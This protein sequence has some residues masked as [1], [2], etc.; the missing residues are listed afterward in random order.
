MVDN[1]PNRREI[2][3]LASGGLC[4]ASVDDI[5]RRAGLIAGIP[6]PANA[7]SAEMIELLNQA[8]NEVAAAAGYSIID[9]VVAATTANILLSG[10]QTIDDVAVVPT[11]RV[12]VKNQNSGSENGVYIAASGAWSRAADFNSSGAAVTGALVQVDGGDQAGAWALATKGMITVGTTEQTWQPHSYRSSAKVPFKRSGDGMVVRSV[13]ETLL[14]NAVSVEDG[15]ALATAADN[16]AVIGRLLDAQKQVNSVTYSDGGAVAA[17][18]VKSVT[19]PRQ[20]TVKTPSTL[21]AKTAVRGLNGLASGL[22]LAKD[23]TGDEIFRVGGSK[24]QTGWANEWRIEGGAYSVLKPG[25]AFVRKHPDIAHAQDTPGGSFLTNYRIADVDIAAPYGIA[26]GDCYSQCATFDR[27][28]FVGRAEQLINV[29]GHHLMFR[30]IDKTGFTG[31]NSDPLIRVGDPANKNPTTHVTFQNL[32]LDLNGNARK[33]SLHVVNAKNT[34]IDGYHHELSAFKTMLLVEHSYGTELRRPIFVSSRTDGLIK[35]VNSD[36]RRD[37]HEAAANRWW[38]E[39]DR[40]GKCPIRISRLR[41]YF[42]AVLPI[43]ED[44]TVKEIQNVSASEPMIDVVAMNVMGNLLKNPAFVDGTAGWTIPAGA[45]ATLIAGNKAISDGQILRLTW[46]SDTD[47]IFYVTQTIA[48][49]FTDRAI[50]YAMTA[51]IGSNGR[52]TDKSFMAPGET[53]FGVNQGRI[54]ANQGFVKSAAVSTNS[55]G[56]AAYAIVN[57]R[58]GWHYDIHLLEAG[59]GRQIASILPLPMLP[60]VADPV[61]LATALKSIASIID[62]LQAAGIMRTT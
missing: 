19:L 22:T 52:V 7:T 2:I 54:Y 30:D 48:G 8:V 44:I 49:N 60:K 27:I 53:G 33:D 36:L 47:G 12:L 56:H 14:D 6:V 1:L 62:T 58:A 18:A 23:A 59:Y 32:V 35:M 40:S 24:L 11:D 25:G 16:A 55:K 39:Y 26:L 5:A 17:D 42:S 28:R 10:A 34:L 50:T 3:Q 9:P 38:D 15:G 21:W 31:T 4:G 37:V 20:Y 61:D 57:P 41:S 13:H 29:Q 46:A 43:L 51:E 45:T